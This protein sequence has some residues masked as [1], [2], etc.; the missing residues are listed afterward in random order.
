[1]GKFYRTMTMTVIMFAIVADEYG[2]LVERSLAGQNRH[3]ELSGPCIFQHKFYFE[4]LVT[5]SGP[6]MYDAGE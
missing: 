5:E 6:A 3:A 1:M 2:W 4:F